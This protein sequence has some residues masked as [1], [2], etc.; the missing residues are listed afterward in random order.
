M[1]PHSVSF[2]QCL[3][4]KYYPIRFLS[5]FI[6]GYKLIVTKQVGLQATRNA[7]QQK[8]LSGIRN[9][10][11]AFPEQLSDAVVDVTTDL[12]VTSWL[13]CPHEQTEIQRV[14]AKLQ[15]LHARW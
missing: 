7:L 15:K 11:R 9:S 8:L 6:C 4:Q 2:A 10:N 14:V 5:A 1:M 12:H 13:V 3:R